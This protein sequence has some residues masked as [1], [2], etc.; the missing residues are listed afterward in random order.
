ML[1]PCMKRVAVVEAAV[2]VPKAELP[3]EKIVK[4]DT[5]EDDATTKSGLVFP[6]TPTTERRATGDVVPNPRLPAEVNILDAGK[7][8]LPETVRLVVDARFAKKLDVDAVTAEK[9]PVPVALVK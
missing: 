6:D 9:N 2:E 7:Y 3:L 8:V 5:P 1:V 4:V